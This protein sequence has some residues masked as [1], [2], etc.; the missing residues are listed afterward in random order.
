MF[1]KHCTNISKLILP[2]PRIAEDGG[3]W[4][5]RGKAPGLGDLLKICAWA[6]KTSFDIGGFFP[7]HF[8]SGDFLFLRTNKQKKQTEWVEWEKKIVRQRKKSYGSVLK[9]EVCVPYEDRKILLKQNRH[10]WDWVLLLCVCCWRQPFLGQRTAKNTVCMYIS[11]SVIY[12]TYLHTYLFLF[13]I[14]YSFC[15]Y[16][17]PKCLISL[18]FRIRNAMCLVKT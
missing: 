3:F 13:F 1:S 12:L 11:T 15:W 8:N 17:Y 7:Y 14:T 5:G 2:A 18:H 4:R 9:V 6:W 10:N 16:K